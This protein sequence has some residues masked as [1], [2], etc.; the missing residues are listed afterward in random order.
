MSGSAVPHEARRCRRIPVRLPVSLLIDSSVGK[1]SHPGVTLDI[2]DGGLRVQTAAHLALAQSLGVVF[3]RRPEACRVAWVGA[4]GSR[5][6][7]EAGLE[8]VRG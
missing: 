6:Q 4:V 5:E 3:S 2:S 8:F 7:G 1:V